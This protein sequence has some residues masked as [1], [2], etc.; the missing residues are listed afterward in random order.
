MM[1]RTSLW[2]PPI[3][4]M[5]IIFYLSSQTDPVP[6]ITTRIW[7]KALHGAA[8]ALLGALFCRALSGEGLRTVATIALGVL[9]TSGYGAADEFHQAFVPQR[10][11]ELADWLVDTIGA[12]VGA[13]AHVLGPANGRDASRR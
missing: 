12:S 13:L 11:P 10:H 2:A 4:C 8:Y 3:A 1:K 5:A 7:D 9:L 6:E